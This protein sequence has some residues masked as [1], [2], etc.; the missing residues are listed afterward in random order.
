MET[1]LSKHSQREIDVLFYIIGKRETTVKEI[2]D[3][4]NFSIQLSKRAILSINEHFES[5]LAKS[6]FI[7]SNNFGVVKIDDRYQE[8]ALSDSN[9]L[10][11]LILKESITFNLCTLLVTYPKISRKN[12]IHKLFIS[13]IYL[14]KLIHKLR[15]Y[16]KMFNIVIDVSSGVYKLSGNELNI[17]IFSYIFLSQSFQNI[18]WPLHSVDLGSLE[19]VLVQNELGHISHRTDIQKYSIYYLYAI[20]EIRI[21]SGNTISDYNSLEDEEI[22]N[23]IFEK[24]DISNFQNKNSLDIFQQADTPEPESRFFLFLVLISS[25]DIMSEYGKRLIGNYFINLSGTYNDLTKKILTSKLINKN[26]KVPEDEYTESFYTITIA[27]LAVSMMQNS[28]KEFVRLLASDHLQYLDFEN[29]QIEDFWEKKNIPGLNKNQEFIIKRILYSF[30]SINREVCIHIFLEMTKDLTSSQHIKLRLQRVFN[31]KN[32]HIID[33][34]DDAD[35]II[36]DT[37]ENSQNNSKVFYLDSI[38]NH[39]AWGHLQQFIL[40]C[41]LQKERDLIKEYKT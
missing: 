23:G 35:I 24:V 32:I 26:N 15:A 17:R 37:F 5:K 36:A 4:F 9:I 31:N 29:N 27:L 8:Q 22:L 3:F 28:V 21:K 16:F 30:E 20:F 18:E 7:C 12:L 13:E 34:I 33:N 14:D 19:E 38:N 10:K 41:Y 39:T 1:I 25:G 40:Q 6:N 11:L 2:S